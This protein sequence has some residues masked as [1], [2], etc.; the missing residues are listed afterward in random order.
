M[1][2]T[3]QPNDAQRVMLDRSDIPHDALECAVQW[4]LKDGCSQTS[5]VG[6]FLQCFGWYPR[7]YPLVD[8]DSNMKWL[9][10]HQHW[11]ALEAMLKEAGFV[12]DDEICGWRKKKAKKS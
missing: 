7:P 3:T 9:E 12:P 4:A 1:T 2:H 10:N 11:D 8:T 5:S 6:W